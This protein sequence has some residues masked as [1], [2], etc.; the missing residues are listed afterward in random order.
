MTGAELRKAR[1]TLG[2][3]WGLERP[4]SME[5]MGRILRLTG[6]D[7]GASVRDMEARESVSGPV[8][9]VIDMLLAGAVPPEPIQR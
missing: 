4:V 9:V 1:G 8:S 7:V 2:Q 6:K 5:E 3:R